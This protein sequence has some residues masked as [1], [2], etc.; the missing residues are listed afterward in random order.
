M[1]M[2]VLLSLIIIPT[3]FAGFTYPKG[4]YMP[5]QMEEAMAAAEEENKPLFILVTDNTS[6]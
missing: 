6:S 4:V 2:F 3:A 5:N 1:K